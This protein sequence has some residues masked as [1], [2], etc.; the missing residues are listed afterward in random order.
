MS[1]NRRFNG[2][3]RWVLPHRHPPASQRVVLHRLRQ[4]VARL[5]PLAGHPSTGLR[6]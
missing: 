3:P 1:L 5:S 2:L 6:P 4:L